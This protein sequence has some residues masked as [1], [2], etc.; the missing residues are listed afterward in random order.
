MLFH[1][2][3]CHLGGLPVFGTFHAP[4]GGQVCQLL[5]QFLEPGFLAFGAVGFVE[6]TG[7]GVPGR[8]GTDDVLWAPLQNADTCQGDGD[9]GVQAVLA[10]P[11]GASRPWISTSVVNPS[12][13]VIRPHEI[14]ATGALIGTP[15]AISAR[16]EPQTEPC[17]VEP[18]DE[19]TSDTQRI[20]YGNSSS[21]GST[22]TRDFSAKAP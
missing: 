8:D 14:P 22:G 12:S 17:D 1:C 10:A 11:G 15:A 4:E 2:A 21:D 6:E 18:F 20:A 7:E 19:R 5:H 9:I 16:V 3:V 13:V